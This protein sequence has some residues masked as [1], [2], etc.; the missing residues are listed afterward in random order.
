[1]VAH[2]R[3]RILHFNVTAHP[4]AEWV[5]RQFREAFPNP[6][7]PYKYVI[8][9]RDSKF[10]G[11][12]DTLEGSG[13]E[14]VRTS[15][16]TPQQNGIAERWVETARRDCFDRVIALSESHVRRL[17][18]EMVAYYQQ[19]RTH[20]RVPSSSPPSALGSAICMVQ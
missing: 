7:G 1:M 13:M 6:P 10:S 11:E 15:V 18:R 8:M 12:V 20:L 9:D 3:R 2:D 14:V 4:T 17:G 19:D 5:C 16:R